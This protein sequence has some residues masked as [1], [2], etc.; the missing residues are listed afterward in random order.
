ME[1]KP[2]ESDLSRKFNLEALNSYNFNNVTFDL[3][4]GDLN[5]K[6]IDRMKKE[7]KEYNEE[8]KK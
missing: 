7:E 5:E 4:F 3:D 2:Q 6:D 1:E 8:L